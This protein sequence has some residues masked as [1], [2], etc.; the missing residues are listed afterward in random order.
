MI[1]PDQLQRLLTEGF[2]EASVAVTDLTGTRDHYQAR[3][4]STDFEGRLPVARHRMV[5]AVL[6]ELMDEA[7]HA[8][9]LQT[10]TPAEDQAEG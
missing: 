1:A 7:I 3:I 6:G 4:V 5:Y 8:L 10:V 9:T 2:T